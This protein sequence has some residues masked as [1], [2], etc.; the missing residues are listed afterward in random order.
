MDR[1]RSWMIRAS[2][3]LLPV[4]VCADATAQ[5]H[6]VSIAISH[7]LLVEVAD[8]TE[9]GEWDFKL[10]VVTSS[11]VF[12]ISVTT[13]G[14][15]VFDIP[16]QAIVEVGETELGV[17]DLPGDKRRWQYFAL[18]REDLASFGDGA[19]TISADHPQG[20]DVLNLPF[21]LPDSTNSLSQPPLPRLTAPDGGVVESPVT[22][23]W[24][25]PD[26]EASTGLFL[27]QENTEEMIDFEAASGADSWGPIALAAGPWGVELA[28]ET[29]FEIAIESVSGPVAA[30]VCKRTIS[31]AEI[32]V[33]SDGGAV[34]LP[35]IDT[36]GTA[37]GVVPL[38][39]DIDPIV[40]ALFS[41]VT[42]VRAANGQPIHILGQDGVRDEQMTHARGVM[43]S[44]LTPRPGSAHGEED[45]KAAVSQ[46]MA[47]NRA[48]LLM[49]TD[50]EALDEDDPA[51]RAF[52]ER[53]GQGAQDLNG[54]ETIVEGTSG[55][56]ADPPQ[57]DASYE[58]I[59]H[60]IQNTGI[61]PALPVMQQQLDE[62]LSAA[63]AAGRYRPLADLETADYDDEYLAIGLEVYYGIWSHDP[64]GDGKAGD[65]EFDFIT[66]ADL[67]GGDP[68]LYSVIESF[69]PAYLQYVAEV[70]NAF[71]G[72]FELRLDPAVRYT[73][74][75]RYLDRVRLTGSASSGL[76]G[77]SRDNQLA[78]NAGDNALAGGDG[79][80]T[81]IFRGSFEEY[82]ISEPA[83]AGGTV[84]VA[85]SLPGRDGIDTLTGF[86]RFA[87]SDRLVSIDDRD[88]CVPS[89]ST[90]CLADGRFRVQARWRSFEGETGV[91]IVTAGATNR[92][93]IFWFFN[94]NT[95]E[96]LAKMLDGCGVNNHYWFFAAGAT[97]VEYTLIVTDTATNS[98]KEYFN[99]LG[100][101]SPAFVDTRAF[102]TCEVSLIAEELLFAPEVPAPTQP[103][104]NP[105][106][107]MQGTACGVGSSTL[108]LH[109]GRFRVEVDW[110][111]FNDRIGDGRVAPLGTD[112]SGVLWFFDSAN[113]ELLI[114]VIDGCSRND[115]FWIFSA[116]T[117]N[118]AYDLRVTDTATGAVQTYSNLLG[119]RAPAVT[120]TRAFSTCDEGGTKA[121]EKIAFSWASSGEDGDIFLINTDG[122]GL[123]PLTADAGDNVYTAF[124]PDGSTIAFTSNRSGNYELYMMRVDGSDVR[125]ITTTPEQ[126]ERYMSWSP[127]G[128]R[129]VIEILDIDT[130]GGNLEGGTTHLYLIDPDGGNQLQLTDIEDLSDGF[131]DW[132]PDGEQIAFDRTV[133]LDTEAESS[134][135]FIM[136]RDG[137][138]VREV[139]PDGDSPRWSPDGSRLVFGLEGNVYL[140]DPNG[141]NLERLTQSGDGEDFGHAT[142]S[143][144][145]AK[146]TY[147]GFA[148]GERQVFV[149]N[150]DGTDPVALTNT[151]GEK[152]EPTWSPGPLP[153]IEQ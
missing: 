128:S 149:M 151:L 10:D 40:A 89:A 118:V 44:H 88:R 55:Y 31:I 124:S 21:Y 69:F 34:R 107:P 60:L 93:G 38:P 70:D 147:E 63:L 15:M 114:K 137:T 81:A 116:A 95:W 56:L 112:D 62:A 101:R 110:R 36:S 6:V 32:A 24:Q 76:R 22:F 144:D 19:Y 92:A 7:D 43:I 125:R 53:Y 132:S 48:K 12:G 73:L 136:N 122:T 67:A 146:L 26:P 152:F 109:D 138:E 150:A 75:S 141:A 145:G 4:F 11:A 90:L 80:D 79:I 50:S 113:W 20:T 106:P 105:I 115:H 133:G 29:R 99:P 30:Q 16:D 8:G 85:D 126:E 37:T 65:D 3:T 86:E 83:L 59:A 130:A 61:T 1:I 64:S 121:R 42:A 33:S 142:W 135:I 9:L 2:L 82:T 103:E 35:D 129:L 72:T 68:A 45:A 100:V 41:K 123:T 140:I 120:D 153:S 66:L 96:V 74:R 117:T 17:E 49:F 97:N 91:G 104:T 5:D 127:D 102:A 18:E 131:P 27:I 71:A 28:F 143:P 84:V 87:F 94:G 14:G 46:T 39:S 111:D 119:E 52:F 98:M 25:A 148:N 78:G 13:P 51:V 57:R 108:C 77:N 139:H 47:A 134:S 58:E 23:S 54:E